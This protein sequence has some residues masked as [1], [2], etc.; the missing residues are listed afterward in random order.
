D[1]S[2]DVCSSDLKLC[3]LVYIVGYLRGTE[4]PGRGLHFFGETIQPMDE[5]EFRFFEFNRFDNRCLG[6]KA[7]FLKHRVNPG[8][9][10]LNKRA[11][12]SL[13]INRF[14]RIKEQPLLRLHLEKEIFKRAHPDII[15]Q[16]LLLL[17]AETFYLTQ[18]FG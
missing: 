14:F 18:F 3:K 15:I 7:T 2:S 13:E 1:W 12:V 11:G 6:V 17:I 9:G 16:N 10:V 5:V 8:I 4:F